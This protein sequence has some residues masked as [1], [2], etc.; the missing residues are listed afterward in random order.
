[1]R[2]ALIYR[3]IKRSGLLTFFLLLGH[4]GVA[5]GQQSEE[6]VDLWDPQLHRFHQGVVVEHEAWV[7]QRVEGEVHRLCVLLRARGGGGQERG[8]GKERTICHQSWCNSVKSSPYYWL[9]S[10]D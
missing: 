3:L 9:N 5:E 8:A 7:G 6:G 2:F 10:A 1:M 4:D